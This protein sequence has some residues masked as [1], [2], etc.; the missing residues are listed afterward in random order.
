MPGRA[1]RI[2]FYRRYIDCCNQHRFEELGEFVAQ[3]VRG[4]DGKEGLDSGDVNHGIWTAGMVQGIIHDI[5]AAGDLVKRIM[6]EAE[7]I[8]EERLARMAG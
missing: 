1:E 4:G 8:I 5:P 3:D 7:A 6:A 2:D